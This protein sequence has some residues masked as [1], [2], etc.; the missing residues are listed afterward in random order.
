MEDFSKM[1]DQ[2]RISRQ[3]FPFFDLPIELRSKVLSY[4]LTEAQPIDL[5]PNNYRSGRQRLNYFLVSHRFHAEASHMFYGNHSFRIF[6]THGRFFSHRTKPL[7]QRLP[8]RYRELLT[9]LELRLGPGWSNPPKSWWVDS[10]LGIEEMV[11]VR[12]LKV[13]VEC[14]PSHDIFKG[15]RIGKDFFT[16]FA[17]HL[18]EEITRR[19]PAL[20]CVE[21][22][23]WPS[24]MREGPLM[25]K[26][27]AV[28]K[29]RAL[30]VIEMHDVEAIKGEAILAEEQLCQRR[31]LYRA[32]GTWH[33]ERVN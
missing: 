18:L 21:F 24:V 6:P 1:I 26:L 15:F 4:N 27:V 16:E 25:K 33:K 29:D 8:S 17:A 20:L 30:K 11:K 3:P 23:G 22:D 14:D 9:T 5:D 31:T 32:V 12:T 7:L 2:V 13:F 10:R 28:A 19:L